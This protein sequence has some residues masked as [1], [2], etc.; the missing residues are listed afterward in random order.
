MTDKKMIYKLEN[1]DK[2]ENVTYIESWFFRQIDRSRV[3]NSMDGKITKYYEE[4]L[5]DLVK[6]Q[7]PFGDESYKK[8]LYVN[9]FRDLSRME[10]QIG[11]YEE[12]LKLKL[13]NTTKMILPG[14][15]S[16]THYDLADLA[17][18][19]KDYLSG[20]EYTKDL[21]PSVI[22]R[23]LNKDDTYSPLY[24]EKTTDMAIRMEAINH[25]DMQILLRYMSE[26]PL[27]YVN[28]DIPAPFSKVGNHYF[29]T[30][31]NAFNYWAKKYE[32]GRDGYTVG[33]KIIT[34]EKLIS[35]YFNELKLKEQR[36]ERYE[37]SKNL[38]CSLFDETVNAASK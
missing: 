7:I 5:D 10:R 19:K 3:L 11:I 16:D 25:E 8:P 33:N 27:K 22:K 30:L 28:S 15:H 38:L 35:K 17:T 29:A 12:I 23:L 18:L 4:L 13:Q 26:S 32:L 21:L 37:L 1:V 24:S 36:E 6:R 9:I 20:V 2:V 14:I 34:E 31:F